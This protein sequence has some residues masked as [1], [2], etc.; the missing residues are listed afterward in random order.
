MSEPAVRLAAVGKMYKI[1][2]SRGANL[3]DALGLQRRR[4]R[5]REFWALRGVD[6]E[7]GR[8]RRLG[9]VG[10]NGAGKSTLLKLIT[11]N[12]VPTEGSVE[13]HGDVQALIEAGAGFHPEF[14]GEENIRA[15]LTLQG[16]PPSA[17]P[18]LI[19]EIAEF[20]ELGEFLGQPFRT[21][22]AGMQARLAFATATAVEPDILIVDEMLSAGDAYFSAKASER[23]R[24]L[25]DSGATL[26]LVS[27]SLDQVTM[28]CD[29]AIWIDRGRIVKRGS[30]LDVTKAYQQFTRVL[31]ERR[32]TAKNRKSWEG[33]TPSHA[34]DDYSDSIHVRISI[35][36]GTVEVDRV[37]L[38][39]DGKLEEEI[40]VGDAQD[41]DGTH[42]AHVLLEG[43]DWTSPLETERGLARGLQAAGGGGVGNIAFNLYAFFDDS[44]YAIELEARGSGRLRVEALRADRV[45]AKIDEPLTSTWSTLRVIP[46]AAPAQVAAVGAAVSE[47]DY[48]LPSRPSRAPQAAAQTRSNGSGEI[49]HWPGEGSITIDAVSLVGQNGEQAVFHV[50]TPLTVRLDARSHASG[51][52]PV[53]ATLVLYRLDGTRVSSHVGPLQEL[54]LHAGDSW[55]M[56][57]HFDRLNLGDGRYVLSAALYR[58][59]E[60]LGVSETYDLVDR[61]YEF[62]VVGNDPFQS[63]VFHHPAEWIL[64]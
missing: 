29:E 42:A 24:G 12:I 36:G 39:R 3:L 54:E 44:K 18:E 25:V 60:R 4:H 48:N 10:R 41:A 57:L 5:Y 31:D 1:F 45:L 53:I 43:S 50:G 63:G 61:S 47:A 16:V 13:V 59:L 49:R 64:R 32:L 26:L 20:T 14:S 33:A 37:R 27:H 9:I 51:T 55:S 46:L 30:S 17:M 35:A 19:D 8:G 28:F 21:Y 22:S 62:E 56:R 15:A 11:R 6:F 38:T 52:F 40:A 58:R 23:M 7:V 2:P 34:L